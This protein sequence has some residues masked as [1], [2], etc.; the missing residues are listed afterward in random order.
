MVRVGKDCHLVVLARG[1]QEMD[2]TGLPS[3][4]GDPSGKP[5][6]SAESALDP[7]VALAVELTRSEAR[8][9]SVAGLTQ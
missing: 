2:L 4:G 7:W 8:K 1:A 5:R 6:L 3:A 9:T